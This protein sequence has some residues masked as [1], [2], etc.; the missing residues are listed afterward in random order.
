M[1]RMGGELN[2][3]MRYDAMAGRVCTFAATCDDF[4]AINRMDAHNIRENW[5]NLRTAKGTARHTATAHGHTPR[6]GQNEWQAHESV[7]PMSRRASDRSIRRAISDETT[8]DIGSG[9]IN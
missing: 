1:K 9:E 5:A 8:R 4:M 7:T 3:S 2:E 6:R